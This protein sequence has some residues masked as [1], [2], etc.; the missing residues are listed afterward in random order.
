MDPLPARQGEIREKRKRLAQMLATIL[1]GQA[2]GPATAPP[3]SKSATAPPELRVR[4]LSAAPSLQRSLQKDVFVLEL[5]SGNGTVA[6]IASDVLDRC[7]I[8]TVDRSDAHGNPT[9]MAT[10]P[11]DN[12]LVAQRCRELCPGRRAIIWASPD[13]TQYSRAKSLGVRDLVAADANVQAVREIAT[14]LDAL[15][16]IIENPWT[17]LLKGRDVI[18]FMPHKTRID[19]CK[20]GRL[21][22][23]P[24]MLWTSHDL[25]QYGFAPRV[26]AYDCDATIVREGCR[27]SHLNTVSD[28]G[29]GVRI[30]VPDTLVSSVF[31]SVHRLAIELLPPPPVDLLQSAG[32]PLQ[33]RAARDDSS[34]VVDFITDARREPDGAVNLLVSWVGYDHN[35]WIA[36]GN[37]DAD[38]DEYHF[39]DERVREKCL[40]WCK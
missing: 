15:A 26:C 12:E 40:A 37:L 7:P 19:Y 5:F 24:T 29:I 4:P 20:Y 28:Y 23:K 16:L 3:V 11:R 34:G 17:G 36:E 2:A 21:Y 8:I 1:G 27:N 14:A 22:Q 18:S 31:M 30:S 39:L 10:L 33:P 6:A 25:T 32:G 13:C 9:I 38:I 35:E